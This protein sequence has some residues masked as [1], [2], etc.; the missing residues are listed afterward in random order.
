[1]PEKNS[2]E[3]MLSVEIMEGSCTYCDSGRA[4]TPDEWAEAVDNCNNCK[5]DLMAQGRWTG[6]GLYSFQRIVKMFP[7]KNAIW[8]KIAEE[9]EY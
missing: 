8:N 9:F 4:N 7:E 6:Y 1:M 3:R 5:M 2:L